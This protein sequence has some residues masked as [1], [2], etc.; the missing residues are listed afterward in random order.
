MEEYPPKCP[1]CGSRDI[2]IETEREYT[3]GGFADSWDNFYCTKC[4]NEWRSNTESG[5]C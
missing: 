5:Y 2:E 4:G 1:Q 3:G